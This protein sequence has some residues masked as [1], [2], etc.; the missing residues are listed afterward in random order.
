MT[1]ILPQNTIDILHAIFGDDVQNAV[2]GSYSEVPLTYWNV[3]RVGT[4]LERGFTNLASMNDNYT[5]VGTYEQNSARAKRLGHMCRGIYLVVLDDIGSKYNAPT[6][7]GP[8]SYRIQTSI[9]D[10]GVVNEQWGYF[11]D[12]PIKDIAFAKTFLKTV[13]GGSAASD[14]IGDLSRFIRL[15]GSNN[16]PSYS[17]MQTVQYTSWNPEFRYSVETMLGW[18]G[19]TVD[20]LQRYDTTPTALVTDAADHPIVQAFNSANLLLEDAPND[21]GWL[22]VVCPWEDKHSTKTGT[23]TGLIIR[24]DGSWH[25]HCFHSS[26][27]PDTTGK[28]N[29]EDVVVKLG[30]LGG[31]VADTYEI[32]CANWAAVKS[33]AEIKDK[34]IRKKPS[35][36]LPIEKRYAFIM[37][38]NLY[39]DMT[40]K[41]PIKRDALD[42]QWSHVYT[43]SRTRPLITR[44]LSRNFNKIIASGIGFHT[45]DSDIF[46]YEGNSYVNTYRAPTLTPIAGDVSLWTRLMQH[47]YG[48]HTELVIDHMAY[49]V[50][51]PE[52]KIR[53]QVLVHGKP[54]TGKTLSI[55]PLKHIF[56]NSCKT[57][58]AVV[59]EKFDDVY[60]GSKVVIFEEIWGDRKSYNHIKSKLANSGMDVLNPKSRAKITQMNRYAMYMFSNHED[61]LSID[62]EGD[63]LLVIK[64]PDRPLEPAFYAQYGAEMISG[65]LFN[66]VYDFLLQRD[67]STF[68]HGM[69]PIRTQAA[70]DM[71][72][73]AA[74]ESESVI[75]HAIQNGYEPFSRCHFEDIALREDCE[76]FKTIGLAY[77]TVRLY[78]SEKRVFGR[79]TSVKS[80]LVDLGFELIRGQKKGYDNTPSIYVEAKFGISKL[81]TVEIF[82]WICKFFLLTDRP[83]TQDMR[84]YVAKTGWTKEN[85]LVD[86][87][88]KEQDWSILD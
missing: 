17:G 88:K 26:C 6:G 76:S 36:V 13:V 57:V 42:H 19:K 55:E 65:Y 21:K 3:D 45:I 56:A 80:V 15:P 85:L 77:E 64:G 41:L 44:V 60:V 84:R 23:K 9:S 67:V 82:D 47:I 35:E 12:K 24:E 14:K 58:D 63:K 31:E 59:D 69:L 87:V 86:I 18:V 29:N 53:W 51:K 4:L 20:E 75:E 43:G 74:P 1:A 68:S 50:Q 2:V 27:K 40:L 48:E 61:A 72:Q 34:D 30:E 8:P 7:W 37:T 25:V 62:K 28:L 16:K 38:E 22:G 78:L 73:A 5:C 32:D 81:R 49:T 70:I 66:K 10:A 54:R 79:A 11:L 71:A 39:W 33:L 83:L 52:E 46:D